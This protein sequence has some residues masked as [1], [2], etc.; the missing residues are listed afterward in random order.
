MG[1]KAAGSARTSG[2][3]ARSRQV[4]ANKKKAETKHAHLFKKTP[5]DF[6]IGRSIQPKQNL[7]RFVKW[8]RYIRI[9]RQKAVLKQRLRVPC[10][11][12]IPQHNRQKPGYDSL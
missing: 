3:M 12:A 4:A 1:N 8:P 2:I 10:Y 9:Q 11:P 7:S 6:R 5:K